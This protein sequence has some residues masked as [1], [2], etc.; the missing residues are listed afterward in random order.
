MT[1]V[2]IVGAGGMGKMHSGVYA[3]LP[4]VQVGG[5]ADIRLEQAQA[6]ADK[7]GARAYAS[8]E[9]LLAHETADMAD[10]CTPSHMHAR[11]VKA[12]LKRGLHVLCE[13]PLALNAV[14]AARMAGM[15][16]RRGL[17]LM[18][19]QV[20]R[21]WP[22]FVYLRQAVR[23]NLYG[24]LRQVL[25]SRIGGTPRWSWDSWFLDS[26]RSGLAPYDLHI[27]D[28]DF[29]YHLLGK[30]RAVQSTRVQSE[31]NLTSYIRTCYDYGAELLVEAESGWYRSCHPFSAGYRAVFDHGVLVYRDQQLMLYPDEGEPRQIKLDSSSLSVDVGINISSAGPY[32]NEIAYFVECLRSG[33]PIE[34]APPEESV[35]VLKVLHAEL[36]SAEN[37]RKVNI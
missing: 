14:D 19:A 32:S 10:V 23:Q 13:K 4:G 26:A 34:I 24:N 7:M 21:F 15:A 1:R 28:L 37:G 29:I 11:H 20:I 22:E 36:K 9:E 25:L 18:A 16:R 35:E 31:D 30:P 17:L 3:S 2:L 5:V 8:L 33:K 6:L 27:H 12:C